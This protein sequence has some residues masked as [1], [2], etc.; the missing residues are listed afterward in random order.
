MLHQQRPGFEE[1]FRLV[2]LK[3][4][5]TVSGKSGTAAFLARCFSQGTE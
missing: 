4:D 1:L 5:R 2:F 3:E